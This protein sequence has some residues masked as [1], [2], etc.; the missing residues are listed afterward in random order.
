MVNWPPVSALLV[1]T[2]VGSALLSSGMLLPPDRAG[3]WAY[4]SGARGGVW[5]GY[6]QESF[7]QFLLL[8]LSSFVCSIVVQ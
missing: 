8:P 5:H 1:L 7:V 2:S 4:G 3:C 6:A